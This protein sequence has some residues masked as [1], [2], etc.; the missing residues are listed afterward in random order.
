VSGTGAV[1]KLAGPRDRRVLSA[2]ADL[3]I[4]LG[5]FDP[6]VL[7]DRPYRA[8]ADVAIPPATMQRP[9][10]RLGQFF[11]LDEQIAAARAWLADP[12]AHRR[13]RYNMHIRAFAEAWAERRLLRIQV[14]RVEDVQHVLDWLDGLAGDDGPR[15]AYLIGLTEAGQLDA[16]LFRQDVPLV[17]RVEQ[18][19]RHPTWNVGTHPDALD[20]QPDSAGRLGHAGAP[21]VLAGPLG[22]RAEDLRMAAL[23]AMRGGMPAAQALA[24]ITRVPA[25]I[26]GVAERVGS[27][28]PGRDADL[29]ILSGDPLAT[30]TCVQ[31]VY[32]DGLLAFERPAADALVVRGGTLW[33]GNGSEIRDGE[34]LI[35]D[36]CIAAIGRRVPHPPGAR[37][38]DAGPDAFITPG[39]IDAY[40]HLGLR[41]DQTQVGPDVPLHRA[42]GVPDATF[43]RVAQA[44]VTTVMLAPYRGA[45]GARLTAI[46]TRGQ[47][48]AQLVARELGGVRFSFMVGDPVSDIGRLKSALEAG[49][50]YVAAWAKYEEE[51][52]QWKKGELA[53]SEAPKPADKPAE[54]KRDDPITGTWEATLA[55]E[56][57]PEPVSLTVRLRLSGNKIEGRTTDPGGSGEDV[58]LTGTLDGENVTLE[59]EQETPVGKPIIKAVLDRE[60]HMTGFV[61]IAQFQI[62]FG[63]TRVDRAVAEFKV[64]RRKPKRDDGRPDPPDVDE[65]LEPYRPLLAGKVPAVVD[66]ETAA[67]IDAVLKLFVD[68]YKLPLILRGARDAADVADE[69]VARR[70]KLGVIVAPDLAGWRS[71]RMYHPVVDLGRRGVPVALQSDREDGARNLP[72]MGLYAVQQ[73]LGGDA[74][75]RAL[76]CDA[77][78]IYKL[79]DRV[80]TLE[81][82]RDGDVLIFDGHPFDAGRQLRR[83]IIRGQEVPHE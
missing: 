43:E 3:T 6:P 60:D 1:V 61:E 16:E 77:A 63:A 34:L 39:F 32:V 26:L 4:T 51:L 37:I 46:K 5:A 65:N 28:A 23:I 75:L 57:L 70:D 22:D 18:H 52:A 72:L 41:G 48:R 44:G 82:G 42:I 7:V 14:R 79:D 35:E 55:G 40:G 36:G 69:L 29:L 47:D 73:G 31:R 74:A 33:V 71:G 11:E 56:P 38:V 2:A 53:K 80:G 15:A 12:D 25:E 50:Q 83:V 81:P 8:S 21:L 10:S 13:E 19:Y 54:Q 66:V 58:E 64:K 49:K 24:A 59:I 9:D 30:G 68:E 62:A 17:L 67:Q 20:P 78:R 76:T 27:L 45:N